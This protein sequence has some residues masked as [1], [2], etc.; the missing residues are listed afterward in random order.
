MR[1]YL[2][3]SMLYVPAYKKKFID[4]ALN[5]NADALLIDLEDAVPAEFKADARVILKE[6]IETGAFKD[7]T[8]FVRLN[9]IESNMLFED[10]NYVL[11]PDVNGYILTKIYTDEDMVFYDKLITQHEHEKG[12]EE[13]HFKFLPL[14]ETTSAVMNVYNIAKASKRT[15]AVCFG[16]EDFLN[17]LE[18]LHKEPP[19]AFDYPRASIALAARAAGVL[20]IDTPYLALDNMEGFVHEEKISFEMGFA[21]MQLIHPKQIPFAN[22]CFMPEQ[23]EIEKSMAIVEAIKE[24]SKAGS[25]VAMLNGKMIGPPMRKRAEKVL[26]IVELAKKYDK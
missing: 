18:G 2:L 24:S 1:E 6:Y 9:P 12:I 21:G 8:V 23:D 25:G 14:I 5:C 22:E 17:D 10:L 16:G 26:E 20:P 15:I 11:H 19:R 3:R 4:S 13:G 7:R